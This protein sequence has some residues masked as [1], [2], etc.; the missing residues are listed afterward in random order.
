V[1]VVKSTRIGRIIPERVKK[2]NNA[3]LESTA[4]ELLS[5]WKGGYWIIKEGEVF[6]VFE[7]V[8]TQRPPSATIAVKAVAVKARSP[9]A[10]SFSVKSSNSVK[11]PSTV[12]AVPQPPDFTASAAAPKDVSVVIKTEPRHPVRVGISLPPMG[13]GSQPLAQGP[14]PLTGLT[15][16]PPPAPLPTIPQQQQQRSLA[17]TLVPPTRAPSPPTQYRAQMPL[18][19]PALPKRGGPLKSCLKNEN[20]M[21]A[22]GKRV[23]FGFEEDAEELVE[24]VEFQALEELHVTRETI[25]RV[26]ADRRRLGYG[27]SH[28]LGHSDRNRSR[29][30]DIRKKERQ[31]GALSMRDVT[32]HDL[33]DDMEPV[34]PWEPK[35]GAPMLVVQTA[36]PEEQRTNASR[37]SMDLNTA[38]E[39]IVSSFTVYLRRSK[40]FFFENSSFYMGCSNIRPIFLIDSRDLSCLII[41][42]IFRLITLFS[43]RWSVFTGMT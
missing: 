16:S 31:E 26:L 10:V 12:P 6:D 7:T 39:R 23:R 43:A 15:I 14:K 36:L 32:L 21:G 29:F 35:L 5:M 20:S 40:L 22:G 24:I 8:S 42:P 28:N 9:A 38:H 27:R 17:S 3:M 33:D 41:P 34:I 19:P 2:F 37:E 13:L 1:G 11:P 30:M 18:A 4:A 25:R